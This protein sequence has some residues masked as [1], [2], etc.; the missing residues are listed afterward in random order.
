VI[1]AG[2]RGRRDVEL[3]ER[4]D[5]ADELAPL[6]RR[7]H[8]GCEQAETARRSAADNLGHLAARQTAAETGIERW[9]ARRPAGVF[10]IGVWR[11]QRGGERLIEATGTQQRFESGTSEGHDVFAFYSPLRRTITH[12]I[13]AIK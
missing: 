3:V 11:R 12:A 9:N 6:R 1:A 13:P 7:R 4:V 2:G 10:G 5:L 8:E